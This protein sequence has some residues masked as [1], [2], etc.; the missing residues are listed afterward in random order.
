MAKDNRSLGQFKL[1]GIPVAPRGLPQI[2]VTFDIDANGI[3]TVSA[4]DKA[5]TKEQSITISGSSNLDKTDIDRM[6][7]DAKHYAAEDKTRRQY[8][9][10]K[11]ELDSLAY[12][13]RNLVTEKGDALPAHISGRLTTALDAVKQA[14]TPLT[15][16]RC[17]I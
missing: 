7:A 13:A 4:K 2:E 9:E 15:K 14:E 6:V 1:A 10:L 12:Q 11:N 16:L 17:Y 5:T 8:I 3:L